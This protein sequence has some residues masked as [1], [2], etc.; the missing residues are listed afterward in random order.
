MTSKSFA[1]VCRALILSLFVFSFQSATAGMIGT[2]RATG[3]SSAQ[4][5]RSHIS[6]LLAREDVARQL[7]SFGVDMK[8]AQ[9][10]VAMLT[11]EEARSLAGNLDSIPAGAGGEWWIAAAIIVVAVTWWYWG[12]R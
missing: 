5:E 10:R 1:M 12:R 4:A 9:D 3:V 8:T 11:D 2:D 7:Q 6:S